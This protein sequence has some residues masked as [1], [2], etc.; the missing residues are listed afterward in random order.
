[1]NQTKIE[2]RKVRDFGGLL[3]VIFEYIKINF[4]SLLKSNLLIGA[5]TILL[6][7]VF[8]GIYQSSLFSFDVDSTVPQI[9]LPFLLSTFLTMVSYFIIMV[10]TYS[11]LRVYKQSETGIFDVEDVWQKTKQN[12]LMM[13]FTVIGYSIILGI[14]GLLFV[15]LGFYLTYQGN[16]GFIFLIFIGIGI[17][18]YL[19][20][21]YSLVFIVRIEEEIT[22]FAALKRS[23]NLIKD[24]WWFTFG[25]T[26]V[27]GLIQSFILYALYI[28][29]YVVM[30]FVTFSGVGSDTGSFSKILFIVTSIITSLG[31]ILYTISTL[32]IAFQYYNLVERKEAPGLLQKVENIN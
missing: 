28:P 5:P 10:V 6:A 24:N 19:T 21:N 7:G 27:V 1:M 32:A 12:F 13:L 31:A 29:T 18:I 15:G 3:N 16:Y 30:F 2:L 25:L 11:H 14:T 23:K 4:K 17:L 20:I 22:F 26:L 9:G 8:L